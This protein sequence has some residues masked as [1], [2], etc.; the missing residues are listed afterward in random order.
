M[1]VVEVLVQDVDG[2]VYVDEQTLLQMSASYE[3][4]RSSYEAFMTAKTGLSA[5]ERHVL[6][7]DS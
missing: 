5:D 2:V 6:P 1:R 4:T 7:F 3:P